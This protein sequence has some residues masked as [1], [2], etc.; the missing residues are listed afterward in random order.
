VKLGQKLSDGEQLSGNGAYTRTDD[1]PY[2]QAFIIYHVSIVSVQE[3]EARIQNGSGICLLQLIDFFEL[4]RRQIDK[5][6]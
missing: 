2:D 1:G 6:N 3:S 4:L 5:T